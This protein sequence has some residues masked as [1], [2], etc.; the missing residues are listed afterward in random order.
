MSLAPAPKALLLLA[1]LAL[2]ALPATAEIYRCTAKSGAVTYQQIPCPASESVTVLD[3]PATFPAADPQERQRLFERE[4]ALDRRLEAQRERDNREAVAR[5]MQP[6]PP[7]VVPE[8]PQL[9]WA[10]PR[11]PFFHHR[12][13]TQPGRGSHMPSRG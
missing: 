12:G 3:L 5:A 10:L 9:I 4:A 7:Q 11:F 2:S 6:P 1:G 8:E 13:P